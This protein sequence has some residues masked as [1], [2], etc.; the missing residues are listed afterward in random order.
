MM[1]QALSLAVLS[2]AKV[3]I[4]VSGETAVAIGKYT[5]CTA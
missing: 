2:A 1:A 4:V 3:D 5:G